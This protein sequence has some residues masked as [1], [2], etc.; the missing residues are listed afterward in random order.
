MVYD[1]FSKEFNT[2]VI[3]FGGTTVTDLLK[4]AIDLHVHSAPDLLPRKMDDLEMAQR[5]IKAGMAGFA[6]KS[7]YF[8]TA[9]RAKTARKLYPECNTIGT[10]T[11]NSSVGGINPMAVEMAAR[12]EA[13][14]VWF[15]TVD[16]EQEQEHLASIIGKPDAKLP[17]WARIQIEMKE[18]GIIAPPINILTKDG[19]LTQQ[20]L[21]V[22]DVIA[23]Y[24]LI[25]AT[26]HL[27]HAE[28][29]E[30][31]RVAHEKKIERI[32]VTHVD[33]P[34]TFYSIED[35][36]KLVSYGAFMEHC[37]TTPATGKVDWSVSIEQINA[38]GSRHVILATDLGQPAAVYPDEGLEIYVSKLLSAGVDE[39]DIVRM[40]VT[41]PTLLANL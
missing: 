25:L 10:I 30:L 40:A 41:N 4:G 13:R 19:K 36:K 37:Y 18:Q 5:I 17:F 23:K 14:L 21:D 7:H 28:T 32:V 8:S 12:S 34:T 39:P 16:A 22:L 33:F 24:R 26:G 31:V 1:M 20:T 3:N 9:E 27:S 29:F 11:L 2:F 6:A 38:I 15:P 35:Q